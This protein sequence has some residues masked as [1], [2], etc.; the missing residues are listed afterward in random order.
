MPRKLPKKSESL[1]IRLSHE[2]KRAFMAKAIEEGRSASE[3]L[4]TSIDRYLA[5]ERSDRGQWQPLRPLIAAASAGIILS[6][7]YGISS[8]ST[9]SQIQEPTFRVLDKNRDGTLDPQEYADR[10]DMKFQSGPDKR[11]VVARVERR[12][13]SLK[14]SSELRGAFAAADS[15]GDGEIT[16]SEFLDS[17]RAFARRRFAI[18]DRDVDHRISIAEF[19]TNMGV[20]GNLQVRSL[21][22]RRD[23]DHDGFLSE[24]EFKGGVFKVMISEPGK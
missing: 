24:D 7:A 23:R 17:K 8:S 18:A 16:Y 19:E 21:F 11:A 9:A 4:R 6:T 13:S 22:L 10:Y 15:D 2:V 20:T 12:F 1:E 3:V 14:D 5:G